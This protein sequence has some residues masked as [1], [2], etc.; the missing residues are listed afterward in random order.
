MLSRT[1][2]TRRRCGGRP[3]FTL[4]EITLAAAITVLLLAALYAAVNVQLRHA[5]AGR[6]VVEQ[7]T[8]ARALMSR[9]GNDINAAIALSDPARYRAASA[10]SQ[11]SSSGSVSGSA[12][13]TTTGSTTT[14]STTTTSSNTGTSS[15]GSTDDSSSSGTDTTTL[16][17]VT[18]PYGVQGDATALHLYVSKVPRELF[19]MAEE[20]SPRATGAV[21]DIRRISY[22]LASE[23]GLFRQEVKTETSQDIGTL[24]PNVPDEA[25]YVLAPEVQTLSFRYFNGTSWQESWDS[26]T[27][28][29]DGV[30]PIGPPRAIEITIIVPQTMGGPWQ[31]TGKPVMRTYRHVVAI[32]TANGTTEQ[33]NGTVQQS[34]GGG[35]LP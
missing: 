23:G 33:A 26:T 28:G 7:S 3:G 25:S 19:G 15:T 13:T 31:Q 11:S 34:N 2:D 18:L 12:S 10:S 30:T 8:L 22:W 17:P 27:T 6:D 35:T 5:Q 9:I 32:A 20:N 1:P 24:P 4:L 14:P 16:A 29:D 21:S